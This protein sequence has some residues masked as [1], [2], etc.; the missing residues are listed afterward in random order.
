MDDVTVRGFTSVE[1]CGLAGVTYR[2]LDYWCRRGW[3]GDDEGSVGEGSGFARSFTVRQFEVAC[4]MAMLVRA[5]YTASSAARV[6]PALA[7]SGS[8][9]VA[10]VTFTVGAA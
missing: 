10:G 7:D 1:V 4:F 6:A 3:L 2:Q 9:V 5:G 8:C